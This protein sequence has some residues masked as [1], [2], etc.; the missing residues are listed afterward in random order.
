[1]EFTIGKRLLRT[2][3]ILSTTVLLANCNLLTRLSEVGDG[4]EVTEIA[5]PTAAPGYR[6]VSMPMPAPKIALS[7]PNSLWRSGARAFFRDQRANDVGDILT[8]KLDIDDSADLKN[9]TTRSRNDTEDG[10]VTNLFGLEAEF[11][12]LLPQGI[13]PASTVS[14]G[15]QHET[16]GDG[17]NRPPFKSTWRR[18]LP[19]FF[20]TEIWSFS[21]A[22]RSG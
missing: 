6:P 22:R 14:L 17:G 13:V 16:E 10:D 3:A 12:K 20:R 21:G 1:M 19:R 4:P 15:T 9:K 18:S 11:T 8:V 2:G 7:S 5:N